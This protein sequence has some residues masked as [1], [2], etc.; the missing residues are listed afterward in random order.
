MYRHRPAWFVFTKAGLL[1]SVLV[2]YAFWYLPSMRQQQAF[3]S[4]M[5]RVFD[6][7]EDCSAKA[8]AD[9]RYGDVRPC[10]SEW[11]KWASDNSSPEPHWDWPW[12]SWKE[13]A[14]GLNH[15][16]LSA[17]TALNPTPGTEGQ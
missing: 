11:D 17:P 3:R 12:A 9:K 16:A 14:V 8:F 13:V 1:L 2:F 6:K 5:D 15:V 10:F 7:A 4:A